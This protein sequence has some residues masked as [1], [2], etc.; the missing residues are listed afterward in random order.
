MDLIYPMRE[1]MGERRRVQRSTPFLVDG[2]E[3]GIS[4]DLSHVPTVMELQLQKLDQR[5][6]GLGM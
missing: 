6:W 5:G 2:F 3:E 4:G 1:T